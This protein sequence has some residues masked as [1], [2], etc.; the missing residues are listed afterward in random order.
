MKNFL[1]YSTYDLQID[2]WKGFR[3][4]VKEGGYVDAIGV[5]SFL[6][7]CS[8]HREGCPAFARKS[9]ALR[10]GV[11]ASQHGLVEWTPEMER[12]FEGLKEARTYTGCRCKRRIGAHTCHW[13]WH[14]T[15]DR[16][17]MLTM[18]SPSVIPNTLPS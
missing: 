5:Q 17:E 1:Q 14:C 3:R 11:Q 15:L 18:S 2:L 16:Q 6:G 13:H 12:E 4:P 7:L 8:Y 10:A 9:A